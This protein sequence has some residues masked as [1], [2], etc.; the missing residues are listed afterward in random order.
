[1]AEGALIG[2]GND[3]EVAPDTIQLLA[4]ATFNGLCRVIASLSHNRFLA[5]SQLNDIHDAMVT[6]LDDPDWRDD[7]FI[8][9]TRAALD[10]VIAQA[11]RE[12]TRP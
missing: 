1:M 4:V 7:E 9:W 3:E 5:P 11:V 10:T 6:P 12:A 2:A 8:A